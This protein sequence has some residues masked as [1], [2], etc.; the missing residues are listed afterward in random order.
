MIK[1]KSA[2]VSSPKKLALDSIQG[3]KYVRNG[4]VK[5]KQDQIHVRFS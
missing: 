2:Q 1:L 5:V 4:G 3:H